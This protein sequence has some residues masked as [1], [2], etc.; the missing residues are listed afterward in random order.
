MHLQVALVHVGVAA[1]VAHI[2]GAVGRVS[3]SV[4]SHQRLGLVRLGADVA[5]VVPG[6]DV[7]RLVHLEGALRHERL[8]ADGAHE[9]PI[10]GV[11]SH[12]QLEA[13]VVRE[14]LVADRTRVQLVG[15]VQCLDVVL[16]VGGGQ[17]GLV[18]DVALVRPETGVLQPVQ[19]Q[20]VVE[21]ERQPALGALVR[22]GAAVYSLLVVEER[23]VGGEFLVAVGALDLPAA[24]GRFVLVL[25]QMPTQG[26]LR[27]ELLAAHVAAPLRMAAIPM[28]PQR[29]FIL[30]A[31]AA[32]QTAVSG[33]RLVDVQAELLLAE[34]F[35]STL[36]TAM[37]LLRLAPV[38]V[39]EVFPDCA[40]RAERQLATFGLATRQRFVRFDV[41]PESRLALESSLTMHA[42]VLVGLRIFGT[43]HVRLLH[44]QR[45]MAIFCRTIQNMNNWLCTRQS[46]LNTVKPRYTNHRLCR[47][48][49]VIRGMY[50]SKNLR[51]VELP[52]NTQ[53]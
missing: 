20:A 47:K 24:A 26:Y 4:Y 8:A 17:V 27:R 42:L 51:Y 19:L 39:P 34:E 36:L 1:D 33:R 41:L 11:Q 32:R 7:R 18:A 28:P 3:A 29:R 21:V 22:L 30:V 52:H 35:P 15:R 10:S 5:S 45:R 14:A 13:V 38:R 12:V 2:P 25:P 23:R 53:A 6:V 49:F 31:L 37:E 44:L 9:R 40:P 16:Q 43:A 50:S 48:I 46:I